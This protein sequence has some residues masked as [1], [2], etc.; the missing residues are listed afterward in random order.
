MA[1]LSSQGS[2]FHHQNSR[3]HPGVVAHDCNP[4][5]GENKAGGG[6]LPVHQP[7]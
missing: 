6:S 3:K 5:T 7:A 2:E 1:E 4:N